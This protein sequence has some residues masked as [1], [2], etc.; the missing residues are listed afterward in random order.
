[1]KQLNR[2]IVI[3]LLLLSQSAFG[4]TVIDSEEHYSTGESMLLK[5]QYDSAYLSFNSAREIESRQA[6]KDILFLA[7]S[8]YG[9][10][11]ARAKS[12]DQN[13]YG[14]AHKYYKQAF[15]LATQTENLKWSERIMHDWNDLYGKIK[16]YDVQLEGDFDLEQKTKLFFRLKLVRKV[17]DDYIIAEVAA[18][19]NQG[20][21]LGSKG[22]VLTAH[23][24]EDS[25]RGNRAIGV[26][27]VIEIYNNKAVIKYKPDSKEIKYGSDLRVGDNVQLKV[28]KRKNIYRGVLYDLASLN[29]FFNVTAIQGHYRFHQV[30]NIESQEQ[31][32]MMI[33]VLLNQ[34]HET[35]EFLI[36]S[37]TSAFLNTPLNTTRFGDKSLLQ[38]MEAAKL[39]DAKAFLSFVA[40]FPAKY[41]G[42]N[43]KFDETFATWILNDLVPASDEGKYMYR[44][45]TQ[46]ADVDA[47]FAKNQFYILSDS[48]IFPAW[49]N[50]LSVYSSTG[51][52]DSCLIMGQKLMRIAKTIQSKTHLAS[53]SY[54]LGIHKYYKTQ[55]EQAIDYFDTAII[56]DSNHINAYWQRASIFM[57]LEEDKKSIADFKRVLLDYPGNATAHGNIGWMLFKSGKFKK[58]APF[59]T[60]AYELDSFEPAWTINAG[61]L[62]VVLEGGH[63]AMAYYIKALKK[64]KAN[65]NYTSG[66]VADFT[67]F[68]EN[69]WSEDKFTL[70]KEQVHN[71]WKEHYQYKIRARELIEKGD[72]KYSNENYEEALKL[73]QA[74]M[75][76]EGKGRFINY[77]TLRSGARS[78]GFIFYKLKRY[79]ESLDYY[80][81]AWLISKKHQNNLANQLHDLKAVDDVY[82]YVN[83]ESERK[84][85]QELKHAV[86]RK[87][88]NGKGDKNLYVITVGKNSANGIGYRFAQ[89]DAQAIAAKINQNAELVFDSLIHHS[90]A[91]NENNADEILASFHK[92]IASAESKDVFMFYFAGDAEGP[93]LKIA[94]NGVLSIDDLN[95]FLMQC[96]ANEQL[97]VLDAPSVDFAGN[98]VKNLESG[99]GVNLMIIESGLTRIEM[100]GNN[101]G[102]LAQK[103]LMAF[104]T[105]GNN[106]SEGTITA[107]NL[108]SYVVAEFHKEQ[109]S[110]NTYF[111]GVDFNILRTEVKNN[112]EDKVAP[113]VEVLE[114][115]FHEPSRG[116]RVSSTKQPSAY[117][118]GKALDAS[119]IKSLTVDGVDVKVAKNGK[120][121]LS[122]FI[123]SNHQSIV[124][125]TE[126][127]RGNVSN[128]T[129]AF[130][131]NQVSSAHNLG[132]GKG[133]NYA[134]LF[135]TN[136]YEDENWSDLKNPINDAKELA[137]ILKSS[138][139]FEVEVV[140]NAS[141]K[142]MQ[143]YIYK[144]M[145]KDYKE[146]DQLFVFVAGHG[147][148]DPMLGGQIVCKDSKDPEKDLDTYLPYWFLTSNLNSIDKCK[149]VFISLDVCFGGGFFDRQDVVHYYGSTSFIN[150]DQFIRNKKA[151]KTRLF[152]TSGSMEYVPDGR[153]NHSPFAQMFIEAL[154]SGGGEKRYLTLSDITNFMGRLSTEPRYGRFGENEL[155]GDFIFEFIPVQSSLKQR[156][157]DVS[158]N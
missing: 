20:L 58:A 46:I 102:L 113:H 112:Q 120:F 94:S 137:Q 22:G 151:K 145:R 59:V 88:N 27:E 75:E 11:Q 12:R 79:N 91:S 64:T 55:Y 23:S 143:S 144:Y 29:T 60:K 128:D 103:M 139:G 123:P 44:E 3:L 82:S 39:E 81:K 35:A 72:E 97:I 49:I 76:E 67:L 131:S 132:G 155:G 100:P 63:K 89:K 50:N 152:L 4:Q 107:K 15:A 146:Q 111:K 136:E 2:H 156:Q 26:C 158:A 18:G 148:Y 74:S 17:E 32:E 122:S 34:A 56:N 93:N 135:A 25:D 121:L 24:K 114:L 5:R 70:L 30:L 78:T 119:G 68:L 73:Y 36:G 149:N 90:Y 104:E 38:S 98:R 65:D 84:M 33:R 16:L 147:M 141:K 127:L 126:D 61:H 9:M 80:K 106:N 40:N 118:I 134:L 45:L 77:T 133:V 54:E 92:V 71:E 19:R 57:H 51:N 43:Y 95:N 52:H 99:P 47:W 13:T 115:N 62:D 48:N 153:G 66:I 105:V 42:I 129:V 117:I 53:V 1:M 31:E 154:E 86:E 8:F 41:M 101:N 87:I 37:D 116:A 140:E 85:Y 109:L 83:R 108:E 7:K 150:R 124:V 69:G 28:Y 157:N 130:S 14:E 10:A 142:E 110:I 6:K 138:Y 125:R 21:F 96:Q